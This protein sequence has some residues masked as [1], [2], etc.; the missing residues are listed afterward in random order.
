M[1]GCRRQR[2]MFMIVLLAMLLG[3]AF[4]FAF[5]QSTQGPI[6]LTQSIIPDAQYTV[7]SIP[8]KVTF[9]NT[10][11]GT[12]RM[13]NTFDKPRWIKL[14]FLFHIF[15]PQSVTYGTGTIEMSKESMKYITLPAKAKYEFVINVVESL[16]AKFVLT[17]GLYK[18]S[19]DYFNKYGE[20]CFLGRIVGNSVEITVGDAQQSVIGHWDGEIKGTD[21]V[22]VIHVLFKQEWSVFSSSEAPILAAVVDIPQR[23]IHATEAKQVR[24]EYPN[25]YFELFAGAGNLTVFEGELRIQYPS[26]KSDSIKREDEISGTCT[27]DGTL[28]S[29]SL[30]RRT[31][32]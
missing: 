27:F 13:L 8:L 1:L 6:K 3:P 10:S 21:P 11:E 17:P 14:F 31:I 9:E 15:G 19:V 16:P 32:P 7:T 25:V 29:F 4:S 5:S 30:R 2:K 28:R 23:G 24:F 22:Q 18:I 26:F 20:N 12:V